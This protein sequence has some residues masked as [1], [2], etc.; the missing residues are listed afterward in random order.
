MINNLKQY[1]IDSYKKEINAT[2][3]DIKENKIYLDKT[4]FYPEGGGQ[5]GD[6]GFINST[7][8]VDTQKDNDKIYHLVEDVKK[9]NIGDYVLLKLDWNHRYYYMKM[10][11]AQHIISGLLYNKFNVRTISTHQGEL[12]LT[13]E[14]DQNH[15]SQ[16]D[17]YKLEDLA[18]KVILDNKDISYIET[19]KEK[20]ELF[21]MRR[22]IK[23]DK[24]I[25]IVDINGID[26]IACGGL[27]VKNTK[28]IE[29]IMY[30]GFEKIRKHYRLI[31]RI[32]DQVSKTYREY[33]RLIKQL[34]TLHS[35]T[36]DSLYDCDKAL[37][38]KK[39]ELEKDIKSL[40]KEN[41]NYIITKL[42]NSDT[43]NIIVKDISSYNIDFKDIDIDIDKAIFLY[44][45]ENDLLK[46]Y[47]YLGKSFENYSINDIRKDVLSHIDGKGGG[48]FPVFQGKGNF[49]NIEKSVASFIGYFDGREE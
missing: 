46:W 37:L 24:M 41:T 17:C 14:I 49:E 39:I 38:E 11:S 35:A 25:R 5:P 23:V 3:L 29:K 47:I 21:N 40:K 10:H 36:L 22:S 12:N 15:F 34:C 33:D 8:V 28:E 42:I 20:A 19:T 43:K 4:I 32:A 26:Q 2:I 45:K 30:I 48:K 6:I 7:K 1:Y 16:E 44:K 27:H 13:I 9:F 31:F 18:N